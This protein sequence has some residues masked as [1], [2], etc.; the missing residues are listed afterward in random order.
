MK[1]ARN[2]YF[3]K[4]ITRQAAPLNCQPLVQALMT[5]M[6]EHDFD[7]SFCHKELFAVQQCKQM[8]KAERD[9]AKASTSSLPY[10]VLNFAREQEAT[11]RRQR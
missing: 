1:I 5:C 2:K 8:E 11:T 10:H 6:R 7:T 3:Q 9:A 4:T